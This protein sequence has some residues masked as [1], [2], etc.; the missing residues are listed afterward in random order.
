L[1]RFLS[2]GRGAIDRQRQPVQ[3][4][5]HAASGP[6]SF[7]TRYRRGIRGFAIYKILGG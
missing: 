1:V 5:C 3:T 7:R 2:L 4:G 6:L